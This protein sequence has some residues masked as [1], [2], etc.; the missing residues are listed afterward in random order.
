MKS[1]L[2]VLAAL[3]IPA[4]MAASPERHHGAHVHGQATATLAQDGR[5]LSLSMVI[6]G[7][8]LVGFEHPPRNDEQRE[9]FESVKAM[10]EA[11]DWLVSDP[12]GSCQ[13]VK[14]EL[15]TPG[16]GHDHDHEHAHKNGH[17]HDHDHAEFRLEVALECGRPERLAW[18]ELD[19][20][21]AF[22]GNEAIRLDLLTE[23][24]ADRLRLGPG[25]SRIDLR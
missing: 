23:R 3:S 13:D 2:L 12:A 4:L 10:L 19:L 7:I 6:P 8:N 20:F 17:S 25:E 21:E 24:R 14:V 5:H 1:L 16:F 18:I 11:G 9:Q 22:P 15:A